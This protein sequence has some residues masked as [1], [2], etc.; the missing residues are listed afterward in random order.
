MK[1][2]IAA[3]IL[4]PAPQTDMGLWPALACDQ[5]TSQP[6]YWQ[7]AE[8]LTQNAP[9]TLHI[10]LPEAYLE[11][12]DVDGRIAAIHTAMADYRSRVLTRGVHGFVYVERATQ[13]GVRQGLVGAVDLEAYSYEK[14]SA[15]LVRPSENTIVERIPPRL[16]VRRGAPLETPHIMMLL[17]DAACGVVEPFAKKKAALEK[18]YDT[19]LMLGGGHIAGWAVT[20]AADIAVVENAVTA[21]GTQAAFDAKYPDAGGRPPRHCE[22]KI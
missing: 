8:A 17:D 14:G 18:L 15:P 9:S 19:E 4:L 2:F 6:E 10:T 5:F 13:S 20:D 16:A 3:D 22:N 12:P 11:S 7:K 21:L 1:P